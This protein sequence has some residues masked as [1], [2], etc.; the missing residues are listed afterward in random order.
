MKKF[1]S[2]LVVAIMAVFLFAGCASNPSTA[3]PAAPVDVEQPQASQPTEVEATAG[4]LFI[5]FSAGYS[6]C[7]HWDLEIKGVA[8]ACTENGV[9]FYSKYA[10]GDMAQQ[11][12]DVENMVEMGINMLI[13]GP[14]NS[15]G[16]VPTLE[17]VKEKGI[18]VA[19][20]DIGVKGTAVVSHVASDNYDIGRIAAEYVG[21]QM[22]GEGKIAIMGWAAASAT[23]DRNAGFVDTITEKYPNIT[24]VANVDVQSDRTKSMQTCESLL[25]SDPDIGFFFGCNADCALG[26]YAATQN[27][28]RTDVKVVAVD[29]DAEVME[30]IQANTNLVATVAQNPYMMGYNAGMNA[31]KHLRGEQVQDIA[32]ESV[33]VTIDNAQEILDRDNGYMNK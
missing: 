18:S 26:A 8:D 2:V 25:Q 16:I 22:G 14:N 6:T 23:A 11:V 27:A 9:K 19:T 28:N 21:E 24:I 4:E 7:T 10:N 1:I 33:L 29:S 32:I 17:S 5:G 20:S 31:I 3:S 12:D 15:D 30:A 13:I